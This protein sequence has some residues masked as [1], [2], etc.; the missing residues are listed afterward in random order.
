MLTR[1]QLCSL[2]FSAAVLWLLSSL[3]SLRPRTAML[4]GLAFFAITLFVART[5]SDEE[6]SRR[7]P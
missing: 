3:G 7:E 2:A 4:L 5:G 6:G 1:M